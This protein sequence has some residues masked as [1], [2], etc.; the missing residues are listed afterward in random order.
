M[1]KKILK[2]KNITK[3]FPGV[4]ALN[5]ISFELDQ[6]E[7]HAI[8]GENGAGKSTLVKIITGV[9]KPT[10]GHIY[11]EDR[12][13]SWSSPIEATRS[14]IAAIY[15][16]PTVFPDL[17]VAENIFMGHQDYNRL[18]RKIKWSNIYRRTNDLMKNLA[19]S[20]KA[21]DTISSLRYS[22]RQLV[23]VV[24]AISIDAKI[25]LMDEPTAALSISESEELFSVIRELKNAGKSLIYISHRIE[26]I[27]KVADRVTV[28]RDGNCIGTKKTEGLS[29][30]EMIQMM[31]G[32][33]V[34]S[35]YP[36]I[37]KK[38]GKEV[39]R[40]E[41]LS[42][43]GNFKDISFTLHEGEILGLYGLIGSGRT[44]VAK[45]ILD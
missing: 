32:R 44:E 38:I 40:V 16:E 45:A 17:N 10:I 27:S 15:Q 5:N 25:I 9:L 3:R 21:K 11:Y 6:G 31:V 23:E 43:K 34:N 39:L 41:N 13:I 35:L 12:E 42:K 33:K 36:R 1:K 8:I 20:I 28:L 30:K 2:L 19:P 22:E 18:S 24:K 37:K 26:D 7:V 4:I 29:R 14:G